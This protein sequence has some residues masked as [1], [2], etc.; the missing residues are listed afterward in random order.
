MTILL[1]DTAT[2]QIVKYIPFVPDSVTKIEFLDEQQN[3]TTEAVLGS[4]TKVSFYW[5]IGV[6]IDLKEGSIYMMYFY[7]GTDIIYRDKC[8]STA[9]PVSTFSVNN[10][11]YTNAPSTANKYIIY[12]Q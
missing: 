6:T 9:Q 1:P 3:V 8:F 12:G 10:G 2:E 5:T 7:N 11:I 4:Q